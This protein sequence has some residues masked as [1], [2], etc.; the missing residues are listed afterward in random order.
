MVKILNIVNGDAVIKIMK[1]ANIDG[2]FL[3]WNDFLHEGPVP[4]NFS[5]DKLSKIRAHFIEEQGFGKLEEIRKSFKERDT[6]LKNHAKYMKVILWFE[7]DL[8]DQLQLLQ[9]LAWFA[10]NL[11]RTT[12]LS[13]ICTDTY[14]GEAS[15]S[16]ILNLFNY[17]QNIT[18]KH[19]TLAEKAWSAF[20]EPTPLRW[21]HLLNEKTSTLPFL[22]GTVKRMLEEFPNTKNGL[23]RTEYQ[24]LLIIAKGESDPRK[25][26]KKHQKYEER[27]F[28][29]D[30]IFWKILDDF[31]DYK[32]VASKQN[33]QNLTITPLGQKVLHGTENWLNIKPINSWIGGVY[34]SSENLWCWDI[35]KKTIKKYYFSKVISSLLPIKQ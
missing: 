30:I 23:S 24:A 5:L 9:L 15:S 3:P 4:Q 25:I 22:K 18:T 1:A 16:E 7:H 11:S 13:L 21:S 8:Y 29:G 27:K 17:E 26:F 14:L 20:C 28:M 34:L 33:G 35:K 32:L 2:D 12:T 10:K 31:I 19:F 6:A